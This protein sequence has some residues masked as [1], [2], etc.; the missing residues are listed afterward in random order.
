M[1][2]DTDKEHRATSNKAQ[3]SQASCHA[4]LLSQHNE[5]LVMHNQ[6]VFSFDPKAQPEDEQLHCF[7]RG[8]N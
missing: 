6:Q 1:I 7:I 2:V 5:V 3:S 4:K 8:Y